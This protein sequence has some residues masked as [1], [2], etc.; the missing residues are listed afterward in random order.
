MAKKSNGKYYALGGV[1]VILVALF[2]WGGNVDTDKLLDSAGNAG[3]PT[4]PMSDSQ[5]KAKGLYQVYIGGIMDLQTHAKDSADAAI[6][7]GDDTE[8]DT[9]CWFPNGSTNEDDWTEVPGGT[10]SE[11]ETGDADIKIQA[12]QI[13]QEGNVIST[14]DLEM[15]CEFNLESSQDYIVDQAKIIHVNDRIDSCLWVDANDDTDETWACHYDLSNI[16]NGV[17]DPQNRPFDAINIYLFDE[18]T[19]GTIMDTSVAS[20]T[21]VAQTDTTT[22]LLTHLDMTGAADAVVITEI[23]FRNNLTSSTDSVFKDTTTELCFD[24]SNAIM[25]WYDTRDDVGCLEFSDRSLFDFDQLASTQEYRWEAS[26]LS[27]GI[28]V[29]VPKNANTQVDTTLTVGTSFTAATDAVC[30]ELSYKYMDAFEN[31]SSSDAVDIEVTAA[32]SV[33]DECTIS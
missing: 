18:D 32:S 16:S 33:G 21:S 22:E 12:G 7:Y 30:T 31:E 14:G 20:A 29:Y 6:T 5:A 2:M 10:L 1:A 15:Y 28:L 9:L 26:D 24:D 25:Q 3:I 19:D 8:L 27:E 13:D 4:G 11:A 23:L 17:A